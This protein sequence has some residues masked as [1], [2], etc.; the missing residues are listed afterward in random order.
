[1]NVN[2]LRLPHCVQVELLRGLVLL[3]HGHI[4]RLVLLNVRLKHL[5]TVYQGRLRWDTRVRQNLGLLLE[6]VTLAPSVSRWLP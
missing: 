5:A 4:I 1:M 6:L 3:D 2:V